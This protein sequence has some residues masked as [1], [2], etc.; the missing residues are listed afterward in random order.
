MGPWICVAFSAPVAA[1]SAVFLIYPAGKE[2]LS[3]GM[4][5][6]ILGTFNFMLVFQVEHNTL[7][8]PRR[9]ISEKRKQWVLKALCI[10]G[11]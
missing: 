8:Y 4:S 5:L 10:Y 9:N 3:D 6:G 7:K 1:A 11:E 2:S